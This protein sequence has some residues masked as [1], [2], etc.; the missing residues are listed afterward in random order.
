MIKE[1]KRMAIGDQV[2]H[3]GTLSPFVSLSVIKKL[4]G[5]VGQLMAGGTDNEMFAAVASALT[6]LTDI[7]LETLLLQLCSCVQ[8]ELS[9]EAPTEIP[10]IE[11]F[12]KVFRGK[13]PE[14]P[15]LLAFEVMRHNRFPFLREVEGDIG[16]LLKAMFSSDVEET[17][18]SDT[19]SESESSES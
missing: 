15:L 2:F 4:T 1:T 17:N 11:H 9:G 14:M 8:V 3:I 12:N 13:D 10:T 5:L 16:D 7:D 18:L 6:N 19:K